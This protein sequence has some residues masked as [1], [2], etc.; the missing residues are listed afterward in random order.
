MIKDSLLESGG[1]TAG[2][3]RPQSRHRHTATRHTCKSLA[4]SKYGYAQLASYEAPTIVLPQRG[5]LTRAEHHH[6]PV[7]WL[8]WTFK[9]LWSD[10][11]GL[12][13]NER[14]FMFDMAFLR[15]LRNTMASVDNSVIRVR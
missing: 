13:D 15:V 2:L 8:L 14:K 11:F 9:V 6:D 12:C 10:T 7:P 1:A 4:L 3:K 5:C